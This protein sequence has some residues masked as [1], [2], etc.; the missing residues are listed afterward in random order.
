MTMDEIINQGQPDFAWGEVFLAIDRLSR[1]QLIV[2]SR[3]GSTYHLA[4]SPQTLAVMD[5]G[6]PA[7][8]AA[9]AQS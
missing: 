1:R 4:L 5:I 6:E 9:Q 7:G 2:L 3:A 8:S